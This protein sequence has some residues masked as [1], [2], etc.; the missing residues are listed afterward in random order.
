MSL[1]GVLNV[2]IPMVLGGFL[3]DKYM[4]T[5]ELE[6]EDICDIVAETKRFKDK[7]FL[8]MVY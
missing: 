4:C 8:V 2:A 3:F 5:G 6:G 7:L 1:F